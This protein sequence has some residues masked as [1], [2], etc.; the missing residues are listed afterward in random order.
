M[1]ENSQARSDA[2]QGTASSQ[3]PSGDANEA[4]GS[5]NPQA[6]LPPHWEELTSRD[7]RTYYANHATRTTA[8]RMS[9]GETGGDD[10]D[11]QAG[12]PAAWQAL[13]NSEGR[14]Y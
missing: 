5:V 13:V 1:A 7:G 8:W 3:E 9:E 6:P 10:A 12:L 4:R 2:N 11:T 14:T